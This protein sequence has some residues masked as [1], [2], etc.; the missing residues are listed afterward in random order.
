MAGTRTLVTPRFSMAGILQP[1]S[2]FVSAVRWMGE[3]LTPEIELTLF[4]W[5]ER[6][7]R[8]GNEFR[9]ELHGEPRIAR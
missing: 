3:G 5:V 6:R 2:R 8:L 1:V 7:G 4:D 9:C